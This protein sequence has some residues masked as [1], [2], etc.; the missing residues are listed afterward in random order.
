MLWIWIVG[1]L[2]L[3]IVLYVLARPW[4][5]DHTAWGRVCAWLDPLVVSWLTRSRQIALAR[6]SALTGIVVTLMTTVGDIPIDWDMIGQWIVGWFPVNMQPVIQKLLLPLAIWA[7]G[8]FMRRA[9]TK[10]LDEK[11]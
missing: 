9:T 3:L 8:E 11:A 4:L 1:A 6:L 10:P 5:C 2:A 7:Y